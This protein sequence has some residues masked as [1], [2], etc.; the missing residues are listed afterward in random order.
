MKTIIIDRKDIVGAHK[1]GM[2][3]KQWERGSV[4]MYTHLVKLDGMFSEIY[5]LEVKDLGD[6]LKE[7][8]YANTD[9]PI[10]S[11]LNVI[12]YLNKYQ[13]N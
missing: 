11:E 13:S 10:I 12:E 4:S 6:G 5:N 3:V 9:R 2:L 1:E 8:N 7:Y